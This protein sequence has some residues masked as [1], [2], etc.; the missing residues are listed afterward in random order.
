MFKLPLEK[1]EIPFACYWASRQ[2]GVMPLVIESTVISPIGLDKLFVK[3][4]FNYWKIVMFLPIL[5]PAFLKEQFNELRPTVIH[6]WVRLSIHHSGA[7]IVDQVA[8]KGFLQCE[9]LTQQESK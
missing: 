9:H 4:L 5:V 6:L 1:M 3:S 8:M 2:S 7:H